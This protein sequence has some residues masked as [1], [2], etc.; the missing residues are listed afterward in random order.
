M[1]FAHTEQIR[2]DRSVQLFV[3]VV[4][5]SEDC[6]QHICSVRALCSCLRKHR[7]HQGGLRT[8]SL[9]IVR[10]GHSL[11][12]E[13]QTLAKIANT[14]FEECERYVQFC[15]EGVDINKDCEHLTFRM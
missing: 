7:R 1:Q 12:H 5:V 2:C 9:Q 3:E 6:E 11:V 15:A 8:P 14:K 10:A 4:D 13:S